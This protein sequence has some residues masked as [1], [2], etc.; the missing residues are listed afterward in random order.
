MRITKITPTSFVSK[1]LPFFSYCFSAPAEGIRNLQRELLLACPGA[2]PENCC[3]SIPHP[4]FILYQAA[5]IMSFKSMG[6]K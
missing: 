1:N 6:V 5:E 3:P 2:R 4:Y